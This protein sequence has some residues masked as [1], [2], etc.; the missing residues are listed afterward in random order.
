MNI[1]RR[2]HWWHKHPR[3]GPRGAAVNVAIFTLYLS[4]IK[5]PSPFLWGGWCSA[6]FSGR[7]SSLINV[8]PR[9]FYFNHPPI[10]QLKIMF[11]H[12]CLQLYYPTIFANLNFPI[13]LGINFNKY[14]VW[15]SACI[16]D[17]IIIVII[18]Q[19]T[20][21][22]RVGA[23]KVQRKLNFHSLA[24]LFSSFTNNKFGPHTEFIDESELLCQATHWGNRTAVVELV[25]ETEIIIKSVIHFF[26]EIPFNG[27]N[28]NE[29]I[30]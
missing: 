19:L 18:L 26:F 14:V 5:E 9:P 15:A 4:L 1:T 8:L 28:C 3:G 27:A 13:S 10:V 20:V 11:A 24:S 7:S 12:F 16:L 2:L 25:G 22:E 21:G 29:S 30:I 23:G 17:G 6:L